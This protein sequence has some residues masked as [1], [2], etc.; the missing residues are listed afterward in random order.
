[1]KRIYHYC[2]P[3]R[4]VGDQ[5]L[6]ESI[7][8]N[9]LKLS[10]KPIHF[11]TQDLKL[12]QPIN[13]EIVNY[14]NNYTDMLLVG[15]GGMIMPGDGFDTESGWQFNISIENLLKIKV[16]IVVY[17][18]GY[19]MFPG[20]KNINTQT[21]THLQTTQR[22]S[23]LFSVRNNGTKDKLVKLG[24]KVAEV[25][26]DPGMFVESTNV[27]LPGIK[28][29]DKLVCINWAGDRVEK[30]WLNSDYGTTISAF[31][32]ALRQ[33]QK[34]TPF[35]ILFMNHVFKYDT[36]WASI[37]GSI[38][39]QHW[40]S[41][42]D[43]HPW[44]YPEQQVYAPYIAGIYK[45]ADVSIGMRGHACIIPWGQGTAT[46]AFGSH[47]KTSF[48]AKDTGCFYVDFQCNNLIYS[49]TKAL[50][51]GQPDQQQ[52]LAEFRQVFDDFNKRALEVLYAT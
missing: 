29:T 38:L 34:H 46:I 40:H 45:R 12:N 52:K 42:E 4:N 39:R 50:N 26:P 23:K 8:T 5:A 1:M 28:S 25:V 10:D 22:L 48:F 27:T 6:V 18:I 17:A 11:I 3:L 32:S 33:V 13:N 2:G 19:N 43:M 15:G 51:E 37:L 47:P 41:L 7:R 49:L 35:E 30:R 21:V 9:L 14:I 44:L 31:I 36:Y 16:P 20:D 24:L